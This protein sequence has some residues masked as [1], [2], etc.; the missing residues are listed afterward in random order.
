[1]VVTRRTPRQP[2]PSQRKKWHLVPVPSGHDCGR[3]A[4]PRGSRISARWGAARWEFRRNGSGTP[5]EPETAETEPP[6]GG[7][8]AAAPDHGEA[9][10]GAGNGSAARV[11]AADGLPARDR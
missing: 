2:T 3:L 10:P 1:M 9:S 5:G 4:G 6:A 11:Q 8:P 7:T